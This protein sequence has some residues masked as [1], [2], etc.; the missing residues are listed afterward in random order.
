MPQVKKRIE[1]CRNLIAPQDTYIYNKST[2]I[3]IFMKEAQERVVPPHFIQQAYMEG[4]LPPDLY[5]KEYGQYT[6]IEGK[7][8]GDPVPVEMEDDGYVTMPER[9]SFTEQEQELRPETVDVTAEVTVLEIQ[10]AM[11]KVQE[12]A[13]EHPDRKSRYVAADG[14]PKVPALEEVLQRDI[15]AAQ[16]DEAWDAMQQ[17]DE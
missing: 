8:V 10:E 14:R 17:K 16:R 7:L 1:E 2:G 9:K 6:N 12:R 11:A 13:A 4:A 15:T 3:R 5:E